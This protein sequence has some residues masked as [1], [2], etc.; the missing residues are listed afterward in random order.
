MPLGLAEYRPLLAN[1][2]RA[3]TV[4][5]L[6]SRG[7]EPS[8]AVNWWATFPAGAGPRAGGGAR[9]LPAPAR[10]GRGRGGSG[11]GSVPKM[12]ALASIAGTAGLL[13]VPIPGSRPPC[14]PPRRPRCASAPS[15]PTGSTAR[16]SPMVSPAGAA[17]AGRRP[18]PARPRHRRGR[19][20]R[21]RRGLRATW[22]AP[23]WPADRLLARSLEGVGTV[24]VVLDPGPA[25]GGRRRAGDPLA[26]RR[27]ACRPGRSGR[28]R[29][30][31]WP[32][33]CCAPWGCPR[34]RELPAPPAGCRWAPPPV[35]VAG[36]GEPRRPAP[37]G[38]ESAEY[39]ES[40]R[41]LGYL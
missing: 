5:E 25:P 1:R 8:L 34:A 20:A 28:R 32:R 19:L 4:W 41:S 21:G 16:C 39:L 40:L 24:A 9:R 22:C 11:L 3:F 35:A 36:Y 15:C 18:L 33:P 26:P 31:P 38:G 12:A 37:R 13:R 29:L 10:E 6:A 2:R 14:R 30:K 27:V 23:S 7:G 17:A